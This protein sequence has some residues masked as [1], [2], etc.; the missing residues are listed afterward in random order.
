MKK[1]KEIIDYCKT[2]GIVK[3]KSNQFGD[4]YGLPEL[5]DHAWFMR[6]FD[7][8][9]NADITNRIKI[10]DGEID[11]VD[12]NPYNE[13]TNYK[14]HFKQFIEKSHILLLEVKKLKEIKR[15]A[16]LDEDFD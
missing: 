5:P 2:I 13:Y 6:V 14:F 15:I 9:K 1:I 12:A 4:Y 7:E 8:G 11:T 3:I 10:I 16:E